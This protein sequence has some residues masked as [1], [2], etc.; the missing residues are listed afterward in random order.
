MFPAEASS[1]TALDCRASPVGSVTIA[2]KYDII[3]IIIII[4]IIQ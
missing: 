1:S 4:I 3:I 2:I